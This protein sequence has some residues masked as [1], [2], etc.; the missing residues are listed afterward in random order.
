MNERRQ[1][2]R[3]NKILPVKI[4]HPDFDVAI[5]ETKNISAN[6]VYCSMNKSLPLMTKLTIL[7]LVPNK[8]KK[9]VKTIT[10]EGVVV[11]MEESPAVNNNGKHPYSAAIYFNTIK[12]AD[13]KA[14][15]A[16]VHTHITTPA[17]HTL[18]A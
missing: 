11:R 4:S 7:I 9:I 3:I 12:E 13:R 14:L 17:T 15:M 1:Y 8:N 2:P 16:Y 10:C 5:T 6:G 18:P